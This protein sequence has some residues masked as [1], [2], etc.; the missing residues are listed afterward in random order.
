MGKYEYLQKLAEPGRG[1]PVP[2]FA[3]AG[4]LVAGDPSYVRAVVGEGPYAVRSSCDGEDSLDTAHAGQQ[5]RHLALQQFAQPRV[6]RIGGGGF[7]NRIG[8]VGMA[9]RVCRQA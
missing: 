1:I 8:P 4:A 2:A 3:E 6:Q 9:G 7:C 5:H